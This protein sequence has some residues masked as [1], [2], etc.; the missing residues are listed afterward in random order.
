MLLAVTNTWVTA[1]IVWTW[2]SPLLYPEIVGFLP[3]IIGVLSGGVGARVRTLWV[4]L[5]SGATVCVTALLFAPTGISL[6]VGG[7][8][9]LL[10]F[11]WA[12]LLCGGPHPPRS[13]GADPGS[14]VPGRDAGKGT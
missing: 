4:C 3:L 5:T 13:D 11:L 2:H 12:G 7:G 8:L 14:V 1:A 9:G 6:V 10:A